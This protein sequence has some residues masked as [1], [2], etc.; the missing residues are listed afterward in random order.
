MFS[1]RKSARSGP[2]VAVE[3]G[4]GLAVGGFS[5]TRKITVTKAGRESTANSLIPLEG[6][7][8]VVVPGDSW[9]PTARTHSNQ[10]RGLDR[11]SP[12]RR[13]RIPKH[14]RQ[15]SGTSD[16]LRLG[17]YGVRLVDRSSGEKMCLGNHI[18]Q[19]RF[20]FLFWSV[21]ISHSFAH[22]LRSSDGSSFFDS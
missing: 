4:A 7:R 22:A 21:E 3:A 15:A 8:G 19:P 20:G 1:G 16:A 13:D 14:H 6:A 9:T 17:K 12:Y 5:F 10:I 2:D 18:H 11:V